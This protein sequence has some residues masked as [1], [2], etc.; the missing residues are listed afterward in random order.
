MFACCIKW[1]Q[2]LMRYLQNITIRWVDSDKPSKESPPCFSAVTR[3]PV[4]T[5]QLTHSTLGWWKKNVVCCKEGLRT[6]VPAAALRR[7]A[8]PASNAVCKNP[9]QQ[10]PQ[11]QQDCLTREHP[12][13]QVIICSQ[14]KTRGIVIK[15]NWTKQSI[16]LVY[17][18]LKEIDFN[19]VI[20]TWNMSS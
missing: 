13:A 20:K 3:P 6:P 2:Y 18:F 7:P 17:Q 10:L 15:L 1:V 16:K 12:A 4:Y 8:P 11:A 5:E 14:G 19:D 9:N